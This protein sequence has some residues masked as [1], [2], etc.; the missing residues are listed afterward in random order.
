MESRAS[1]GGK[2]AR[3]GAGDDAGGGDGDA[4]RSRSAVRLIYDH[5]DLGPAHARDRKFVW[6]LARG[7]EI[8]RAFRP[9]QG[10]L[11]NNELAALTGLPKPTVSRLTYTLTELGYL[12]YVPRLG[13]YE[14]AAPLLALSHPVLSNL[15][16]RQVARDHMQALANAAGASVSIASPDRISMIYLDTCQASS[17]TRLRLEVGSRVEMVRSSVGRAWLAAIGERERALLYERFATRYQEE[18]P[19]LR[20]RVEDAI[21]QIRARGFC[22]VD[23]EWEPDVRAVGVP[24]VSP[25]GSTVLAMNCGAGGLV[26]DVA[27]LESEIGPRLVHLGRIIAPALGR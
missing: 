4:R 23:R 3:Q 14:P 1:T 18:W 5:H 10:A 11:G 16:L 9:G 24:L 6:A 2:P 8:L 15:G 17:L 7:L 20:D 22:L 27:R 25:D 26:L 21:A 12:S 13:R 19:A